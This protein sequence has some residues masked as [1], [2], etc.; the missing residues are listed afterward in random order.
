MRNDRFAS[1]Q[2]IIDFTFVNIH[3]INDAP[4]LESRYRRAGLANIKPAAQNQNQIRSSDCQIHPAITI[5]ANQT[6][7]QRMMIRQGIHSQERIHHRHVD[8]IHELAQ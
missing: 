1:L 3:M 2:T 5:G 4:G 8:N 6:G 7:A